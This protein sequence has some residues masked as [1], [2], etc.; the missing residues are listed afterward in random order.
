MHGHSSKPFGKANLTED[1][2]SGI[3][4]SRIYSRKDKNL[5][6]LVINNDGTIFYG[7]TNGIKTR[8]GKQT[9]SLQTWYENK[10]SP[11]NEAEKKLSLIY[12]E[13]HI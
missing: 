2:V 8:E 9:G 12:L 7:A 4:N 1:A 3:A 5:G 6:Y 11:Y 10:I 13:F